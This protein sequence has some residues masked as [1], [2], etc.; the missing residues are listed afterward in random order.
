MKN[1][2]LLTSALVGSLAIAGSAIAETKI[3][4]SYEWSWSGQ[5][6]ERS[7]QNGAASHDGIGT[8]TQLNISNSGDLDNGLQYSAGFSLETDTTVDGKE[9]TYLTIGNGSTSVTFGHDKFQGLDGTVTP[10]VS[11]AADSLDPNSSNVI[12]Y[13][14]QAG[15]DAIEDLGF[16]LTQKLGDVGTAAIWYAR[17]ASVG[18]ASGNDGYAASGDNSAIEY[19]FKGNM[20]VDGLTVLAGKSTNEKTAAETEDTEG[21]N[22]GASYNFG[23][24]AVGATKI[25]NTDS[26]GLDTDSKEY[27]VTFAANDQLSVGLMYIETD[28]EGQNSDEEIQM[29]Q[30][31]YNMG[32]VSTSLNYAMVEDAGGVAGTDYDFINLRL[33]TS[34]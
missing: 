1:K 24:F 34:F 21:T 14:D 30:I 3:S 11:I 5:S 28:V 19:S 26:A 12:A 32:G 17:D 22:I 6:D 2:L 18:Q 27:G 25:D 8:E 23:Q 29:L 9:G 4:G 15:V 31:G 13:V 20:G 10:K 7:A 33:K 16:G